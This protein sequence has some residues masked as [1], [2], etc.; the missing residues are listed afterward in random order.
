M[1]QMSDQQAQI[2]QFGQMFHYDVSYLEE[3]LRSSQQAFEA[4]MTSSS[5]LKERRVLPMEASFVAKIASIQGEDCGSCTQLNVRMAVR[6]GM[7]QDLLHTLLERPDELPPLLKDIR[8]HALCL[9]VRETPDLERVARLR[10]AYGADGLA[11]IALS[12]IESRLYPT[13]KRALGFD[14]A[15]QKVIVEG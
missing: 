2:S 11:E 1:S 3:L 15:C 4:F 9:A 10:E 8:E 12:F 6:A 14:G 13:M 5:L 7:D